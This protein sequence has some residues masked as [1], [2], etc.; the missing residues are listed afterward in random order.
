MK[1]F[2]ILGMSTFGQHLCQELS[3]RGNEVMITDKDESRITPMLGFAVSA[4]IADCTNPDVLGSLGVDEFD[5]C[6]V[7]LG[8]N[9][10][11]CLEVTYLLKEYGAKKVISEINRDIEK[12]F[13][14]RNGADVVIYPEKDVAHRVAGSESSNVIFD[15]IPLSDGYSI[16]EILPPK[17]WV[18]KTIKDLQIREKYNV[19]LIAFKKDGHIKPIISPEYQF[20][21]EEHLIV[22][23]TED[24]CKKV[25]NKR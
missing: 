9:F 13:L 7:C 15:I 4:K 12:K 14:L 6:F 8:G 21:S 10:S 16:M 3:A 24:D 20:S 23:S 2:L 1:S 22:M 19:N 18:G 25:F 11:D 17:L 5:C